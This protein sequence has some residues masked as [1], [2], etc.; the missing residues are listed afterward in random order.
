MRK[1]LL[2]SASLGALTL[3]PVVGLAATVVIEPEVQTWAMQ[4]T[5]PSVTFQG[6]LVVGTPLPGTVKIMEV[7]KFK[8]YG[9][10][11]LNNKRVLVDYGTRKV[12][13]IY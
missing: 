7:P 3:L 1:L 10:A 12:I 4:Q 9:F 6:N 5:T 8:K 2:V 11:Y 13:A